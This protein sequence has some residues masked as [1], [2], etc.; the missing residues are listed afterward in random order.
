[1]TSVLL[2]PA[3]LTVSVG[4]AVFWAN[5]R[6]FANIAFAVL[7]IVCMA[8]LLS[9]Y[10][11]SLA[12]ARYY[13]DHTTT[14]VPFLRAAAAIT[15]FVPWILWLIKEVLVRGEKEIGQT[16]RRSLPWAFIGGVLAV[17]AYTRYYYPP[18]TRPDNQIQ[19]TL[20]AWVSLSLV[21]MYICI[22]VQCWN[23]MRRQVGIRRIEMQFI[24]L[25]VA[26]T[27]LCALLIALAAHLF[28]L[29]S[30][31]LLTPILITC[32]YALGAW[33][34]IHYRIFD[35]RYVIVS[36]GQR[37]GMVCVLGCGIVTGTIVFGRMMTQPVAMVLC[38]GVACSAMF[39]M[40]RVSREWLGLSGE[41]ALLLMRQS[42][43]RSAR[44]EPHPDKLCS[45]F[46]GFLRAE[47][48]A[49]VAA[50]M[51]DKGDAFVG[52]SLEMAKGAP[53]F[54]ALSALGWATPESLLRRR[55]AV[56]LDC[57]AEFL[58]AHSLGVMIAVPH[59]SPFPA[60]IMA[61]GKKENEWPYTYPEVI[62][63]Q[64]TAELID[65]I[66]TRARL[67]MQTVLRAKVE[68]LAM[69]SRGLAHDLNNLITPVSSFLLATDD[70]FP[71]GS[72]ERDVQAAA[73]KSV[74]VMQEYVREALFFSDRMELRLSNVDIVRMLPEV[75]AL[76]GARAMN[77]SVS[78][79][80]VDGFQGPVVADA[81]LLQRMLVNL[82]A[83]AIDASPSGRSV[84]LASAP[85]PN[86]ALR[87]LVSDEGTGIAAE[88]LQRVF[89]PYFTTKNT[90]SEQRGFGLG[91]TI[92]QKIAQL[93]GG[94][95]SLNSR[96]GQ[97]TTVVVDLPNTQML[98]PAT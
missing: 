79:K 89:D 72:T 92:C 16:L 98:Q 25:N 6:R 82:V 11:A 48:R 69:M 17:V 45:E 56:G 19:G 65:N 42:V 26:A 15:M 68:H 5:P 70:R 74:A 93:H 38:V 51:L 62:K 41:R 29:P 49:E 75:M 14:A 44:S 64:S 46:E 90:G 27:G 94:T 53:E 43:V 20:Y 71:P 52:G 57:L 78:L 73:R 47:C 85:G 3:L 95:I 67:T 66:L 61:L 23:E 9:I 87:L 24:V 4:V 10:G 55:S 18:E 33:A 13:S 32:S 80:T 96:P 76:C 28:R 63:L 21:A 34:F 81:V 88:N 39:W 59:G 54:I 97:G 91:L 12:G 77:R 7:A 60:L 8:F 35:V 31:R 83:N 50:L 37:A 36:M 84:S 1:M 2:L 58:T 86:G 40:D 22:M 30:L